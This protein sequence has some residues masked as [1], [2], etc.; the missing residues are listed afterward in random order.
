MHTLSFP[1]KLNKQTISLII[2]RLFIGWHFMYEGLIKLIDPNWS[3]KIFLSQS[4]G[5]LSG[6]FHWLASDTTLLQFA[7]KLNIYGLILIGLCLI[8]G[9][10]HK[11]TLISGIIL[12]GLY[13]LAM[14]PFIG[15]NYS[16]PLEGNYLLIN[17]NLIEM[18]AMFVLL[19]F[20][21]NYIFGM[22]RILFKIFRTSRQSER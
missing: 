10:L 20:P 14:P 11:T 8:L 6:F 1:D 17:K 12:I 15:L 21:T 7:D 3:A 18:A 22:D 2:L 16:I 13:Y 9:I 4:K 5:F 19:F